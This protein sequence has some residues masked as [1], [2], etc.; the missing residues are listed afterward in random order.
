MTGYEHPTLEAFFSR[1]GQDGKRN[2]KLY[3]LSPLDGVLVTSFVLEGGTEY[4]CQTV[5]I[6]SFPGASPYNFALHGEPARFR[7]TEDVTDYVDVV[8]ELA[9]E[10]IISLDGLTDS[11]VF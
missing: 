9:M 2:E 7:S 10:E 6:P 1:D 5:L 11:D 8:G 4:S 3:V